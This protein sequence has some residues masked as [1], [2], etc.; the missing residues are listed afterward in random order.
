MEKVFILAHGFRDLILLWQGGC[1]RAELLTSWW[2][3]SR[4]KGSGQGRT[5]V[6]YFL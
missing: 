5:P 6:T 1:G 2:K 3:G 4:E